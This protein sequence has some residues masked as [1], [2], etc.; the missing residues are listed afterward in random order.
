MVDAVEIPELYDFRMG[1]GVLADDDGV[2]LLQGSREGDAGVV[3][4]E[5]MG[6]G[7]GVR[8]VDKRFNRLASVGLIVRAPNPEAWGIVDIRRLVPGA[9]MADLWRRLGDFSTVA[10]ELGRAC[11]GVRVGLSGALVVT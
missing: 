5:S 1:S 4:C 9:G 7:G 6:G 2:M 11:S 3:L 8:M 10:N